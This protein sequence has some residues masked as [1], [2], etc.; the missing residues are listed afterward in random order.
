[1][2]SYTEN[3][4][5]VCLSVTTLCC[6]TQYRSFELI[7][8][9][10]KADL[11]NRSLLESKNTLFFQVLLIC[12]GKEMTS[13]V[14]GDVTFYEDSFCEKVLGSIRY[15][16][17]LFLLFLGMCDAGVWFIVSYLASVPSSNETMK[18][19]DTSVIFT[20]MM[21]FNVLLLITY[22][23]IL[24]WA[25]GERKMK[26]VG[27]KTT[28]SAVWKSL[29][30]ISTRRITSA[31]MTITLALVGLLISQITFLSSRS[32]KYNVHF[33]DY[34][35]DNTSA[36]AQQQISTIGGTCQT[37]IETRCVITHFDD[38]LAQSFINT[39]H[40][41]MA[42]SLL[43][44]YGY[45]ELFWA[46]YWMCGTSPKTP[47]EHAQSVKIA[48][49]KSEIAVASLP[50]TFL[51]VKTQPGKAKTDTSV[52]LFRA[53][54]IITAIFFTVLWILQLLT[55][56][57]IYDGLCRVLDKFFIFWISDFSILSVAWLLIGVFYLMYHKKPTLFEDST[58]LM[59]DGLTILM[60][61][62]TF[63]V[64]SIGSIGLIWFIY[65]DTLAVTEIPTPILCRIGGVFRTYNAI[66]V[67]ASFY[68]I[69]M[70]SEIYEFFFLFKHNIGSIVVETGMRHKTA[71]NIL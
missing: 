49:L 52:K 11:S 24:L 13:E 28:L 5:L 21:A 27:T 12:K 18:T 42:L 25:T 3:L 66:K 30:P 48:G 63:A 22:G 39:N 59:R 56:S 35:F 61:I 43:L 14:A 37:E 17:L 40:C 26:H 10:F 2:K 38:Y 36:V 4:Y 54:L 15:R 20:I 69:F 23:F 44:F 1:M 31:S 16:L 55:L 7:C 34:M 71:E 67:I 57:G 41:G 33:S 68:F 45:W 19:S 32:Q 65:T 9:T 6:N 29:S 53:I 46:M 62:L 70:I 50:G 64:I 47:G 58:N 8:V 51:L 60:I